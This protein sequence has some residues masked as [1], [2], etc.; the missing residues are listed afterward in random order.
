[1][2]EFLR[3]QE[4]RLSRQEEFQTAMANQM[5]H[6][7]SQIQALQNHSAQRTSA[8]EPPAAAAVPIVGAG[9]KL[10]QP[11]KFSGEPG[12]CK[13]FFIDCSLHYELFPNAFP[14][15]RTK[16]AFM[17]SHLTGRAKA[18]A[19]AEWSQG[20]PLCNS[21]TDFK[22]ALQRTFDPVTTDRERA[23]ELSRLKQGSNL[24]CDYAIHFRTLAAE[25]G[26]NTTALYDVFLKGLAAP[27]QD[28]LVPLD[29]PSDLDSLIALAIRTDNRVCQLQQQR[30]SQSAE[31]S[32]RTQAP[33]WRDP[34]Q[35]LPEQR[36]LS[37]MEGEGE[38]MQLGR[39]RLTPEERRR[40]QQEG[41]CF[42]C[43]ELGHR[44]A[45]C[46]AKRS[47]VVSQFT[48]SSSV[49]R[50]LTTVK[51]IHHT[52]TELGA[53]IDS[54]ADESLMDWGLAEEL[55]LKS[56]LLVK[57]INA[58]ALNGNELFTITHIS[59]PLKMHINGH[60]EHIRFYLFK[61]PS[62]TLIL[63]LPWLIHHNPQVNWRTG[64][65]MGWGED[66]V[67]DCLDVSTQGR[68][69]TVAN[70]TSANSTIDSEYPDL[71]SV[72]SCYHHLREVFSKTRAMTVPLN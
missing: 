17:M 26:W 61:S 23:Q 41:W 60:R 18:W 59:E 29:L 72:P 38:P 57:P 35:S 36:R 65:I 64:Q 20:S 22:A 51:V 45:V 43:G 39:A 63:G 13:T 8:P 24:V 67:G 10:A 2:A 25:S 40:R 12:L 37:P 42:Y 70:L 32:T 55:G 28:L 58:K 56:E 14:T 15:D 6:L 27:I 44:A 7:G 46:S 1:M 11:E 69:V 21:L 54:G 71:S 19:S 5:S 50:T 66:C 34:R 52:A 31:R 3:A 16:I 47:T 62:Q 49:S 68:D 33:C 9:C 48:V 30:S 4:A 53:L